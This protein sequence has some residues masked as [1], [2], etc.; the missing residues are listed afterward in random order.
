[1]KKEEYVKKRK[2]IRARVNLKETSTLCVNH[3][4]EIRLLSMYN[5]SL[6]FITC[7]SNKEDVVNT[8][9]HIVLL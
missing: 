2:K 8:I 4:Q 7:L 6:I 5:F 1:M 3:K 9:F